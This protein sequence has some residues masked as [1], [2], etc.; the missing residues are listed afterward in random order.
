MS[1]SFPGTVSRYL[2]LRH[3]LSY[4]TGTPPRFLSYFSC[5][6]G[7]FTIT[8][9]VAFLGLVSVPAPSHWIF[10]LKYLIQ[11]QCIS[12]HLFTNESQILIFL[13]ET[14]FWASDLYILL[15]VLLHISHSFLKF[16]YFFPSQ[17]C[18]C[19]LRHCTTFHPAKAKIPFS[20][21]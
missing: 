1:S 16:S 10:S 15:L 19:Y 3:S 8:S 14:L 5:F 9:S 7:F 17:P 20:L 18:V 13:S 6:S 2:L 12:Y 11:V 4:S 21:R